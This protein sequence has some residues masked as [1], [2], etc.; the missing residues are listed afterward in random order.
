MKNV[1]QWAIA[2]SLILM[3]GCC[4]NPKKKQTFSVEQAK[5]ALDTAMVQYEFMYNSISDRGKYPT[6]THEDGRTRWTPPTGW[7]SG[8]FPGS[9]WY[10][11]DYSGQEKFKEM[12][13]ITNAALDTIKTYT[14][15][16]DIGFML[17]CSFGNGLRLTGNEAYKEI[18]KTGAKTL[19]NR[20]SPVT[21]T[22][23]SW[24]WGA[25]MG[26]Q[27]PVIIDN[28]MNLELLFWAA[29]ETGNKELYDI[30]TTH[31]NTTIK[32][33][34]RDDF[35]CYH[36]VDYDT[37]N[38]SIRWRGTFQGASDSSAWARG[39]SWGLYGYTLVYR[40]TK[41]PK[42]LEQAEN[43]AGFILNHPNLPKDMIPYWDFN[44]PSIPDAE[45]DASAAALMASCFLELSQYVE[46]PNKTAY[47]SAAE[48]ILA[49]LSSE[50]YLAKT[51]D[52]NY[53]ILK[54][55]VGFH[56]RGLEIDSPI[57]Y[58]DYY[59]IEALLR[60]IALNKEL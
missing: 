44:A 9:L 8:F 29:K 14:G 26:W 57:N 41:D 16:H 10:L 53:F 19:A 4:T 45:R 34:Y 37:I 51:G 47:Y 7:T 17:Y 59:Y 30:A 27:F 11:Y 22:T 13:E 3:L 33:H 40:E 49:T 1:F 20:Y 38:G 50:E 12:A 56:P 6:S 55:S 42:Y 52:N 60:Y 43:I 28:M 31:A 58:T 39:Q 23:L 32:N 36:V 35:S 46:E 25:R 24:S 15:T 2:A 5:Q 54:H 21:K 48:K 18:L